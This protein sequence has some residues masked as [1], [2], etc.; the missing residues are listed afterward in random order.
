MKRFYTLL[1]IVL[2]FIPGALNAEPIVST[3]DSSI[4]HYL[5]GV[6]TMGDMKDLSEVQRQVQILNE[7]FRHQA[8]LKNQSSFSI[9]N[10]CI[11]R[12]YTVYGKD[13]RITFHNYLKVS[14]GVE[15]YD[16]VGVLKLTDEQFE[17]VVKDIYNCLILSVDANA[18]LYKDFAHGIKVKIAEALKIDVEEITAKEDEVIPEYN[19]T[20]R[21][22]F[23]FFDIGKIDFVPAN[24]HFVLMPG[25]L[26]MC[27]LNADVVLYNPLGRVSDHIIGFPSTL[28]HELVHNNSKLQSMPFAWNFDVEL[29]TRYTQLSHNALGMIYTLFDS[30]LDPVKFSE[31]LYFSFDNKAAIFRIIRN[32]LPSSLSFNED[33]TEFELENIVNTKKELTKILPDFFSEFYAHRLFWIA[34]NEKFKNNNTWF[35]V[36]MASKYE[37]TILRDKDDVNTGAKEDLLFIKELEDAGV[38]NEIRE[39]A[40]TKIKGKEKQ[41]FDQSMINRIKRFQRFYHIDPVSVRMALSGININNPSVKDIQA[42]E[43]YLDRFEI[44][45][46]DLLVQKGGTR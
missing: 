7:G 19:I 4:P 30:Y 25:A 18:N 36:L 46:N 39:A 14:D 11:V 44:F 17:L 35:E 26:G 22:V 34:I 1:A 24:L 37:P 9:S 32:K 15:Y 29:Q 27:Y 31:K 16:K 43:Q 41:K 13:V 20:Y 5:Q 42:I 23:G 33:E 6:K 45:A 3:N 28:A 38:I 2:L 8:F 21:D 40:W 12:D 10:G